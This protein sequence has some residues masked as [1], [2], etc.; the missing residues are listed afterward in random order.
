MF[1]SGCLIDS[2]AR[3]HLWRIGKDFIHG[4]GHGVGAALNVHEGSHIRIILGTIQYCY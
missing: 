2:Y 1:I 4:V 3:E